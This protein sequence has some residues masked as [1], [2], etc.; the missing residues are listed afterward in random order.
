MKWLLHLVGER[1]VGPGRVV[2]ACR[3][4]LGEAE[5]WLDWIIELGVE[6]EGLGRQPGLSLDQEPLRR[7][8]SHT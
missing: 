6:D 5:D 4:S 7:S 8:W 3:E 2:T 1:V